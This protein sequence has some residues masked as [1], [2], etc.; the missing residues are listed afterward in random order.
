[1]SSP[2]LEQI[3]RYR[4][5]IQ[6]TG[7]MRVPGLIFATKR[8][9]AD[10]RRDGG[11]EQVANVAHLPGIVAASIAMPD[12][13]RGYGF[14]IGGVAAFDLDEG[15]VSPGGVGYDINCGVRLLSTLVP[16][17]ELIPRLDELATA[18]FDAVPAGVG[19][20]GRNK[21]NDAELTR[22]GSPGRSIADS[23]AGRTSNRP[24]RTAGLK[25]RSLASSPLEPGSGAVISSA[26]SVREITSARS[27]LRAKLRDWCPWR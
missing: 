10:I 14:S 9:I 4:W 6:K 11:A 2:Q 18:L 22:M 15:V 5:R 12:I 1:M 17:E 25:D 27:A 21:L 8:M 26:R 7:G 19:R 24:K 16:R 23:R 13:H 3:D 20:P